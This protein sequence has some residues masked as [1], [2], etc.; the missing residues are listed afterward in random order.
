MRAF[1]LALL[2]IV[3]I[4]VVGSPSAWA[5]DTG[6]KIYRCEQPTPLFTNKASYG[7]EEYTPRGLVAV[8]P[9]GKMFLGAEPDAIQ[10][11]RADAAQI[12][13]CELYDEWISLNERTAGGLRY[14]NSAQTS[15]YQ[16]LSNIFS[17]I[18]VP[19]QQCRR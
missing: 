10:A 6:D 3:T 16:T 18:G 17:T 9:N 2:M 11:G 4:L 12:R 1:S 14:Q 15:R 5:R 7:C 13:I 8:A 19:A